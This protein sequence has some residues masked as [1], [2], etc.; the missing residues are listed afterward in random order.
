MPMFFIV[1]L[2]GTRERRIWAAGLLF[3][4]TLVGSLFL[5]F[6][7]L[8]IYM[9]LNTTNYFILI[10][11]NLTGPKHFILW[12]FIFLGF[13]IKIPMFPFHVW[14]PEAHVE[15]PTVGSVILASLLLKL[16]GYGFL[17]FLLPILPKATKFF[18]PCVNTLC[19]LG[20]IYAS[21]TTL[22]QI[23]LKRVIAYSSVAHMNIAVLGLFSNTIQGISGAICLMLAHGLTSGGLF[24]C[25]GVLYNR[26]HTRLIN[27]YGGLA[28]VMPIFSFIFLFFSFANSSLPG[29]FNF[30]GEILILIGI[31]EFNT[32]VCLITLFSI[33]LGAAYSLWLF[34]RICFGSLKTTHINL[35]ADINKKEFFVFF[36]LVGLTIFFGILP[37]SILSTICCSTHILWLHTLV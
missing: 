28:Q 24:L 27:Y 11:N 33:V 7:I 32:T 22:R 16:G 18:L 4:Y 15:A 1:G 17:R 5:L 14:L 37:D 21:L 35:F 30:V 9:E 26:Y 12:A 25:I 20:I 2:W 29:T 23:D 3:I 31:F 36:P 19:I 6:S 10:Y 8:I 13:A 34:N